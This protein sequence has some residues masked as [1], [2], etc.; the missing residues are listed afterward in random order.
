MEY[1]TLFPL[2]C[3]KRGQPI[4]NR[5][6]CW[7]LFYILRHYPY[8][9]FLCECPFS[10]SQVFEQGLLAIIRCCRH[11]TYFFIL[12]GEILHACVM[13]SRCFAGCKISCTLSFCLN[14]YC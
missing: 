5:Y 4:Q 12:P 10:L 11:F 6:A 9:Y 1:R 3:R 8:C 2:F 7:S 14:I 13:V